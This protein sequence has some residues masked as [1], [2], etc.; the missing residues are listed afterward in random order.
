MPV[1]MTSSPSMIFWSVLSFSAWAIRALTL[2][3]MSRDLRGGMIISGAGPFPREERLWHWRERSLT[4]A[5]FTGVLPPGIFALAARFALERRA[6]DGCEAGG[7]GQA[8]RVAV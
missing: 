7:L 5:R 1:S 8:L 2:G 6:Q 4:Y 3:S